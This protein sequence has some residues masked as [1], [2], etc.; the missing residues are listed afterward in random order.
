MKA[1]YSEKWWWDPMVWLGLFHGAAIWAIMV[2]Y[3]SITSA[4]ISLACGIFIGFFLYLVA[5]GYQDY[6]FARAVVVGV[7]LNL[8]LSSLSAI[9]AFMD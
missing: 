1:T 7:A 8:F 2:A 6:R 9:I 5:L 4:W 3:L